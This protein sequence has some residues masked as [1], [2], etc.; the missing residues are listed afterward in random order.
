[1]SNKETVTPGTSSE[2]KQFTEPRKD[3]RP[4]EEA[5]SR[6]HDQASP[7]QMSVPGTTGYSESEEATSYDSPY[8][9]WIIQ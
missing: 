6:I 9:S 5:L 7:N 2:I 4:N 3:D 8:S 1:M